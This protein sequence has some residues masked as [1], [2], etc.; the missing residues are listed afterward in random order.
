MKKSLIAWGLLAL[1]ITPNTW[2]QDVAHADWRPAGILERPVVNQAVAEESRDAFGLPAPRVVQTSAVELGAPKQSDGTV[3]RPALDAPVQATRLPDVTSTAA[4]APPSTSFLPALNCAPNCSQRGFFLGAG[5][6]FA[7][8]VFGSNPAF[9]TSVT[10]TAN[11]PNTTVTQTA[12]FSWN[13]QATPKIWAGYVFDNGWGIQFNYWHFQSNP[14]TLVVLH[15]ADEP[16]VQTFGSTLGALPIPVRSNFPPIPVDT[17]HVDSSLLV[18]TYDMELIWTGCNSVGYAKAGAG[19]RYAYLRQNY[20]AS[21]INTGNP[22]TFFQNESNQFAGAGP[23]VSGEIGCRVWRRVGLY[24][25][26]RFSLLFGESSQFANQQQVGINPALSF[27]S[28]NQKMVTIPVGEIE[29]GVNWLADWGRC[30][31]LVKTGFAAQMWWD[32]GSASIP[33][34]G[35]FASLGSQSP[36]GVFF[37]VNNATSSNLGFLGWTFSVGMQY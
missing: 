31:F 30:R 4:A 21:L 34:G 29:L 12:D 19:A 6:Y 8:P 14:Q 37:P 22:P 27:T 1:G 16:G 33:A 5:I 3:A 36:Q 10:Q 20:N 15:P 2:A 32:A 24:G 11:N 9:V 25:L 28:T 35:A 23:T 17:I 13:F 26:G 18:D 7:Q